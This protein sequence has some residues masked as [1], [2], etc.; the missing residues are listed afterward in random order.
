MIL[1]FPKVSPMRG[2]TELPSAEGE[3]GALGGEPGCVTIGHHRRWQI[4]G[5][6][7]A[8]FP[9]TRPPDSPNRTRAAPRT[10]PNVANEARASPRTFSHF[11][12]EAG[13][14]PRTFSHFSKASVVALPTFPP[15]SEASVVAL[16]TFLNGS[17]RAGESPDVSEL[18]KRRGGVAPGSFQRKIT[19]RVPLPGD[20]FSIGPYGPL[21]K[22]LWSAHA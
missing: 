19:A 18:F 2:S 11:S 16:R 4:F 5:Q 9:P 12:N 20:A 22:G 3:G 14:A 7:V 10:H 21:K 13:E 17:E 8:C 6:S 15:F 1:Y